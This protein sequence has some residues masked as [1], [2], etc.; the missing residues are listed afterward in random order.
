MHDNGLLFI[1]VLRLKMLEKKCS[2]SDSNNIVPVWHE[3]YQMIPV[4]LFL[5]LVNGPLYQGRSQKCLSGWA[6]IKPGGQ[7]A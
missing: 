5:C 1:R 3:W 6:D 4:I 2:E 7:V